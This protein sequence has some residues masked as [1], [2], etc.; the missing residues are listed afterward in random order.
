MPKSKGKSKSSG[1]AK[2]TPPP[3]KPDAS[4]VSNR[5]TT[6]S[7]PPS[8]ES[9]YWGESATSTVSAQPAAAPPPPAPFSPA[10]FVAG[11][12]VSVVGPGWTRGEIEKPAETKDMG[13]WAA[14]VYSKEQARMR[15]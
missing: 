2:A 4:Q 11:G 12:G 3:A 1:D 9:A 5:I 7:V 6:A 8:I 15:V 10:K 14:L 13:G